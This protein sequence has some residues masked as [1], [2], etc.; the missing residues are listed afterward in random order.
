MSGEKIQ[1]SYSEKMLEGIEATWGAE[2]SKGT[3]A[4]QEK[5]L[6]LA[7]EVIMVTQ[8]INSRI[9]HGNYG[10][11]EEIL[12]SLIAPVQDTMISYAGCAFVVL[13]VAANLC[14]AGFGFR[15]AMASKDAALAAVGAAKESAEAV[16]KMYSVYS[17]AGNAIGQGFNGFAPFFD[18][19]LEGQRTELNFQQQVA[20]RNQEL[21]KEAK[22]RAENGKDK[23]EQAIGTG[24]TKA[25]EAKTYMCKSTS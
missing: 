2:Q 25:H 22:Q 16:V 3:N 4:N 8:Q 15:A 1:S 12:R 6:R 23:A 11:Q 24:D 10:K 17:Q 20:Q 19:R 21:Q 18:K 5:M 13:S 9:R 14:C 7:L